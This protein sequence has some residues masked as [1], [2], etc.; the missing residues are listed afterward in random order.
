[1]KIK[2]TELLEVRDD[3]FTFAFDNADCAVLWLKSGLSGLFSDWK[4]KFLPRFNNKK[5]NVI[6]GQDVYNELPEDI[7]THPEHRF[8]QISP[9]FSKLK[10]LYF[11]P[12]IKNTWIEPSSISNIADL[13]NHAFDSISNKP[14]KVVALNGILGS[15]DQGHDTAVDDKIAAKM[16]NSLTAW[17]DKHE[18]SIETIYLVNK[19][20]KGFNLK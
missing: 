8:F 15:G 16:I 12:N 18:T 3:I 2:N 20:G 19:T 7:F 17:L 1:M 6:P 10:Y 5:L 14:I 9:E 11:F 13:I 4:F